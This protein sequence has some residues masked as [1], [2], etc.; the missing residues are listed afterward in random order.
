MAICGCTDLILKQLLLVASSAAFPGAFVPSSSF[1]DCPTPTRHV[2][3]RKFK[4]VLLALGIALLPLAS[5]PVGK[6]ADS[7][8][9]EKVCAW[10]HLE[11]GL[12][13]I[14]VLEGP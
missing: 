2:G 6:A 11:P 14:L 4:L 13:G 8:G 5:W 7:L 10:G 12:A 1:P 9:G 3:S